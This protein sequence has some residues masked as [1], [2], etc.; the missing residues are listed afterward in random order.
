MRSDV[1]VPIRDEFG[2]LIWQGRVDDNGYGRRGA[3]WAHR[4]AWEDAFG[5]A[6]PTG[7]EVHHKCHVILCVEPTHLEPLTVPE[8]GLTRMQPKCQRGHE[9]D[10]YERKDGKGRQCR[11]CKLE[12][13][14]RA[15]G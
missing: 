2:C 5:R 13:Q 12:R 9:P 8:H 3:G 15:R 6:V 14:Q 1:P 4:K 10:W 7:H 11:P